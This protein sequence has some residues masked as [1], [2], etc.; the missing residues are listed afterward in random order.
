MIF[1]QDYNLLIYSKI[2]I[3]ILKVS[4]VAMKK[5]EEFFESENSDFDND[6]FN[7]EE[8]VRKSNF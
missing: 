1:Y 6:L 3:I 4:K 2:I 8:I 5:I 7:I